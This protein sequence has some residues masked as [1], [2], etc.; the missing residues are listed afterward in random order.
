MHDGDR[1]AKRRIPEIGEERR[2]LLGT[3]EPLV[4]HRPRRQRHDGEAVT[5]LSRRRDIDALPHPVE[6]CFGVTC[7]VVGDGRNLDDG[8]EVGPAGVAETLER[9]GHGPPVALAKPAGLQLCPD[10]ALQGLDPGARHEEHTQGAQGIRPGEGRRKVVGKDGP[11]NLRQDAGPVD[12]RGLRGCSPMRQ[13][14]Q[15]AERLLDD[16]MRASAAGVGDE[17]NSAHE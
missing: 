3:E 7:V 4:D 1:A 2:Q 8:G 11:R 10:D 16:V 6:P 13:P 17:S 9:D 14:R 5:P 12:R 15:R